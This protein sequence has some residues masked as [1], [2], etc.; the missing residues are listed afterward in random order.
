VRGTNTS[1]ATQLFWIKGARADWWSS[2]CWHS[3]SCGTTVCA[4]QIN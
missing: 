2:R 3:L 1:P 4:V